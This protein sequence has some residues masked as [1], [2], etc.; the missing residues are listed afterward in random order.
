MY[1]I[2][3]YPIVKR[4]FKDELTYWSSHSFS[5]GSIIEVPFR[6]KHLLA[7]VADCVPASKAKSII[8]QASFIT[9]KIEH[10]K[11]IPVVRRE[12]VEACEQI[13]KYYA[14]PLGSVINACVPDSILQKNLEQKNKDS[15]EDE[16]S[17]EKKYIKPEEKNVLSD[18]LVY[19]TN[20][21]DRMSTYKSIVREEFARKK[22]V[23]IVAPTVISAE[24]L[25]QNLQKGIEDYVILLHG[26]LSKKK[27]I[28]LWNKALE[29]GH[30][31]LIISTPI[32]TSLPRHDI[33]TLIVE[34]ESSRAYSSIRTPHI[35]WR[36][37]IEMYAINIGARLIYGDT[38]LRIETLF[39]RENGELSDF[40]PLSYRIEKTAEIIVVDTNTN[41][42]S[43]KTGASEAVAT[44]TIETHPSLHSKSKKTFSIL[45]EELRSMIEYTGKKN[46]PLFIFTAR[47]G[48]S[49]QTVCGD[50]AQTV[51]CKLCKA[52]V[53]LHQK[54]SV[55]TSKPL[56]SELGID[57]NRFFLCHHCGTEES[58]LQACAHCGS[59]KLITLG[60]G[61]E[62]VEDEIKKLFPKRQIFRLDRDN[63]TTDKQ[64]T[65]VVA[66]FQE[67][68]D[69]IL[70]GTES[71]LA[72][73]PEVSYSAIASLDSLFSIPDFRIHERILHTL[74]RIL[75]KTS[76]YFLI[77]TRDPDNT[78]LKHL[79]IAN[80]LDFYRDEISI[81]EMLKYPPFSVH[82]KITIEGTKQE[83]AEKMK[84]LQKVLE[85]DHSEYTKDMTVFPAFVPSAKGKSTLHMLLS[86]EKERWPDPK[87]CGL[88]ASLPKEY[89]VRVN[90]ESLL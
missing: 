79:K 71:S 18:L 1:I 73:L 63:A 28:E 61:I 83:A 7:L 55:S 81:R 33:Q 38:F 5:A 46:A 72:F 21:P 9:K 8:K 3:V 10:K 60:I 34:R 36:D 82:I 86:V 39:R 68:K 11:E 29:C 74:L 77:Q 16:K 37:Y 13:S 44:A 22:S 64:A 6:S 52:P 62:G 20:T 31:L 43:L 12:C 51:L 78:I 24:E 75:E 50:C 2:T 32:F 59:W 48:L 66:D 53:V 41:S 19:Q 65:K 26:G 67:C 15:K 17:E 14:V 23:H 88:F 25:F 70:L 47:R 57:P 69:G 80:V 58:A 45:S 85:H 90:P 87:L 56:T 89:I 30:S 54:K 27:Q 76:T 35:D 42:K 49:P 4:T 84:K 40:F